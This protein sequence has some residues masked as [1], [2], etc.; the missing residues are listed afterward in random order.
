M[1][2]PI[3]W[4]TVA[5]LKPY[6]EDTFVDL[7]GILED[8]LALTM[9][10]EWIDGEEDAPPSG[11]LLLSGP[12][13]VGK[14]L[15]AA[16]CA[17]KAQEKFGGVIPTVTFDCS[18][19]TREYHLRGMPLPVGNETVFVPGPL[20]VAIEMANKHRCAFLLLEE[21]SSLT[22]GSQKKLNALTDWRNAIY[23]PQIA[24]NFRLNPGCR[25]VII[26]SLNPY[27][28]GGVNEMNKD[29]SSRFQT[30]EVNYPDQTGDKSI[31]RQIRP[32]T[33]E[34]TI[35]KLA[36][37][38][39]ETR[40]QATDYKLAPRDLKHWIDNSRKLGSQKKAFTYLAALFEG[41]DRDLVQE[42]IKDIFNVDLNR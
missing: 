12:P 18:E 23:I 41:S 25:I 31:L 9:P 11:H 7:D 35:E 24:R 26:G 40:T 33:D 2:I 8:S 10:Q 38:A 6:V 29:L 5:E 19:D 39:S 27:V 22:P 13:G 32:G 42:K 20:P 30:R 37:L 16:T 14:S 21:V 3:L 28:F 1:Q 15:L 34:A 4:P 36:Q 17:K